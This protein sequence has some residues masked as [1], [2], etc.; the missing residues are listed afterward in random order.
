MRCL[1]STRPPLPLSPSVKK[2]R[3]PLRFSFVPPLGGD[4]P[5][6]NAAGVGCH[7]NDSPAVDTYFGLSRV[8]VF[9]MEGAP[10]GVLRR[11]DD[12]YLRIHTTPQGDRRRGEGGGGGGKGGD[13]GGAR[14]GQTSVEVN[15]SEKFMVLNEDRVGYEEVA[16]SGAL[17]QV[18]SANR[19]Y[20]YCLEMEKKGFPSKWFLTANSDEVSTTL[21][22]HVVLYDPDDAPRSR[23][24]IAAQRRD[25]ATLQ[26]SN[27][28]SKAEVER[29][30]GELERAAS[31][32]HESNKTRT[33]PQ[34]GVPPPVCVCV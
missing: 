4:A 8:L 21:G 3:E 9:S 19:R 2:D 1:S 15:E 17:A 16:E 31:R 33:F 14:W 29:V 28:A 18:I 25:L 32:M 26:A 20:R 23:A 10:L 27:Q 5:E 12:G 13:G 34:V 11:D 22:E 7:H 6:G 24:I 30:K